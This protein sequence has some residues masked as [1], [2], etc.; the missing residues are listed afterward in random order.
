MEGVFNSEKD[1]VL[2]QIIQEL[3]TEFKKYT[4]EKDQTISIGT[5]CYLIEISKNDTSR[6]K[7]KE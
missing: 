3:R 1:N 6:I 7:T 2:S 4:N 5:G